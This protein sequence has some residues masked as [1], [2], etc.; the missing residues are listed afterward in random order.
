M[1]DGAWKDLLP[2]LVTCTTYDDGREDSW[3]KSRAGD[4]SWRTRH[5]KFLDGGIFNSFSV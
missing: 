2:L 5:N 1:W 3:H 4:I